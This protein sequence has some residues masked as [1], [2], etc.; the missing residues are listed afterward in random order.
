MKI[1][2]LAKGGQWEELEKFSKSVRRP[3]VGYETLALSAFKYRNRTEAQKYLLRVDEDQKLRCLLKM[4]LFEEAA[5]FAIKQ[6]DA[7]ALDTVLEKCRREDNAVATR[8]M[9]AKTQ[10]GFA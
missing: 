3:P 7:L 5:D 2:I 9:A 1:D 10:L 6:K 8:I 4:N